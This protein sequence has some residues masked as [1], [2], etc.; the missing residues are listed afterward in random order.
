MP[1][2]RELTGLQPALIRGLY[3]YDA[4]G[5]WWEQPHAFIYH[6]RRR[7]DALPVLIKL[8]RDPGSTDWGADW[9]QRD[10]QIAQGLAANCA[11]KPFAF[12]QTDWG[13]ALVYAN[14]GLGASRSWRP[15]VRLTSRP[16]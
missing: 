16:F 12:E 8:L 3:G 15:R 1:A 10:Y 5:I 6:G 2:A 4:E 9:L 7:V 13:P 14:E 11:V